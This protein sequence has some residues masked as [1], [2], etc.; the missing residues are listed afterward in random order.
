MSRR[1]LNSHSP[2]GQS[3]TLAVEKRFAAQDLVLLQGFV[4]V[5]SSFFP[6]YS[7]FFLLSLSN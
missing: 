2:L 4:R 5:F 1:F 6:L 3:L 7:V